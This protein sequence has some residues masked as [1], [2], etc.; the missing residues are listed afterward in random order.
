MKHS[1]RYKEAAEKVDKNKEYTLEEAVQK[2]KEVANARFNE[3]IELHVCLGVDPR[4]TDQMIRGTVLLPH[5]TG[6][7]V[8]VLVLAKGGKDNEAKEAGADFAGS[9]EL[10]EKI[11]GGWFDY[12]V[13]IA[14][15]DMMSQVGKLGKLLGPRGLMP[16][17]KSGT[18]TFEVAEAVKQV[19]AGKIDFR[20]D[21]YGIVHAAI[22]RVSFKENQIIENIKSFMDTLVRL[23]PPA[24]KGQYVKKVTIASTMGPGIALNRSVLL[25]D[26]R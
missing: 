20:V 3:S 1:K 12:D 17:P 16:N 13:V 14:T 8:R 6:K 21:R 26:L 22:G 2:L 23:R 11:S 4:R 5:G 15:P 10:I 18:V 9:D 25:A 7:E 24:A 19:K